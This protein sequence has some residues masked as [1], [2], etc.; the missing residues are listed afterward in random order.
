MRFKSVSRLLTLLEHGFWETT[1]AA[2]L[3]ECRH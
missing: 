1:T 3:V 2:R